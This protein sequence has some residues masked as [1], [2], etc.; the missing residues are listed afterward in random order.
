MAITVK[1]SNAKA[2]LAAI[3]KDIDDGHIDTWKYDSAGDFFHDVAQWRGLAWL[4]PDASSKDLVLGI[5]GQK[6]VDMTKAVYGVY[7]GRFI[8]M[9]LTHF[10]NSFSIAD[11]SAAGVPGVDFI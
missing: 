2:L 11:A 5:V 8:E 7:H 9:L 1:T 3:K 6:D 4:R 10:D